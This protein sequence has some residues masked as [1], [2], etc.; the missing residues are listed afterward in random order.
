MSATRLKVIFSPLA[1]EYQQMKKRAARESERERTLTAASKTD[2][3][4]M[5]SSGHRDACVRTT[6]S[7]PVTAEE[8]LALMQ[9]FSIHA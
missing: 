4:V 8:R 7:Q 9:A 6:V 5:F 3:R 2:D 1:V